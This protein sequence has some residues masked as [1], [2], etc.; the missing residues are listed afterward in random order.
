MFERGSRPIELPNSSIQ[1]DRD[2]LVKESRP[3]IAGLAPRLRA[4][5]V[6]RIRSVLGFGLRIQESDCLGFR[7]KG[8]GVRC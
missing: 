8:L 1:R 7:D 3:P 5:A 2:P 4:E 6:E